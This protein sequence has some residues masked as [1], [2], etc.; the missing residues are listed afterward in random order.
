MASQGPWRFQRALILGGARSGKSRFAEQLAETLP[1][2]RLYL[3]TAEAGDAEMAARIAH[4]QARRGDAWHTREEPL[5]LA[6]CIR[7]AQGRYGVILVDCLTLWLGNLLGQGF[8]S[9]E[10]EEAGRELAGVVAASATPL[11]L[12]SNEVGWGIVPDNPLARLFRDQAG[13]LHQRLAN[14]VDL[15]VMV[16]A[17]LPMVLKSSG[18]KE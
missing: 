15:V 1:A 6:A 18:A 16:M 5:E 13:R 14:V 3:A 11:I 4:H 7:A 17:G 12:V 9:R 8:D 2:P 10:V